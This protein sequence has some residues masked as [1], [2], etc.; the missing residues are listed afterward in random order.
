MISLSGITPKVS[1]SLSCRLGQKLVSLK[2]L[3]PTVCWD[4]VGAGEVGGGGNFSFTVCAP[5]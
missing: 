3:S 4:A 1:G 5:T 2:L